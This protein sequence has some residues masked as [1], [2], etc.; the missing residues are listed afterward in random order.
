MEPVGNGS[1]REDKTKLASEVTRR[2]KAGERGDEG[3][4]PTLGSWPWQ[5]SPLITCQHFGFPGSASKLTF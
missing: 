1:A 3:L 4:S 5:V 2:H